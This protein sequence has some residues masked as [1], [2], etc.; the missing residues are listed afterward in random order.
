M[1]GALSALEFRKALRVNG[2]AEE[3][4]IV[5]TGNQAGVVV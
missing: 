3:P 4:I 5:E 2:N 1:Q